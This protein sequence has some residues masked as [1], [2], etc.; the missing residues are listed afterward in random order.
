MTPAEKLGRAH[1]Y[2]TRWALSGSWV[3]YGYCPCVGQLPSLVTVDQQRR[4]QSARWH[5][6]AP[7]AASGSVAS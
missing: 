2:P 4:L 3:G 1:A 6:S 7:T 5:V